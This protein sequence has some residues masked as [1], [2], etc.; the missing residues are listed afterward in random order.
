MTDT[1]V[2]LS[3]KDPVTGEWMHS[4]TYFNKNKLF[5][6]PTDSEAVG[7]MMA[8]SA[9]EI[10]DMC[11]PQD[12]CGSPSCIVGPA[13]S[14][15]ILSHVTASAYCRL[16][17]SEVSTLFA[18]K[19]R[20]DFALGRG[21]DALVKGK[22]VIVVEDVI[23]SGGSVRQ[24]A[25]AVREAGGFVR[26]VVAVCNRGGVTAEM[27]GVEHLRSIMTLEARSWKESEVPGWLRSR[28]VRTDIGH[29]KKYLEEMKDADSDPDDQ[30]EGEGFPHI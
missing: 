23:T 20:D 6:Y 11:S 17:G 12:N 4:D 15:I 1:H 28:P 13:V 8:E 21:Y 9:K 5:I 18:E 7:R 16:S 29:G 2:I 26:G 27:L 30:T 19:I 14:G 10:A 3:K 22:G 24:T 25:E